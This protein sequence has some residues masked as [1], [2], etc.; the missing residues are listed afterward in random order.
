[1]LTHIAK[2]I[3][4]EIAWNERFVL[5]TQQVVVFEKSLHLKFTKKDSLRKEN[6]KQFS[7][8]FYFINDWIYCN[9]L[10]FQSDIFQ[11]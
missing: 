7:F 1:M 11:T 10:L 2:T 6:K 9:N 3:P 5:E 4:S 8:L